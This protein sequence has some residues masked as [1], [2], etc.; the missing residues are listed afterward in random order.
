MAVSAVVLLAAGSTPAYVD[1]GTDIPSDYSGEE[2]ADDLVIEDHPGDPEGP[3]TRSAY[4]SS[5]IETFQ[6]QVG[7]LTISIP[8]GCALTHGISDDGR[9]ITNQIAGVD[10]LGPSALLAKFCNTRLEFHYANTAGKT[11]RIVRGPLNT[12]CRTGT[13]NTYKIGMD[14][15]LPHY[16]KACAQMFVN[17]KRRAVTCHFITQ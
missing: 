11:Y 3:R 9:R 13:V 12:T 6:Y 14:H 2:F 7:G 10:C 17:G 4:G 1:E 5:P 8:T 16:G 15:T